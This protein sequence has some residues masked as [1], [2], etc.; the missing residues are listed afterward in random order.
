MLIGT[1]FV[2]GSGFDVQ[3]N[4]IESNLAPLFEAVDHSD[5]NDNDDFYGDMRVLQHFC[6][7]PVPEKYRLSAVLHKVLL[8]DWISAQHAHI[9]THS[10]FSDTSFMNVVMLI[11]I[12]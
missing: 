8:H 3:V 2:L 9:Q 4:L 1:L 11:F 12:Y 10:S 7:Y 6:P 5:S